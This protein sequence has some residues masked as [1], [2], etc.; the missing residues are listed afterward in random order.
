MR[1]QETQAL[2]SGFFAFFAEAASVA[3][4]APSGGG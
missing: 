4:A 1:K 2:R 3:C